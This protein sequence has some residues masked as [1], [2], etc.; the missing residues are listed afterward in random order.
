MNLTS[1]TAAAYFK[2]LLTKDS[3]LAHSILK[4]DVLETAKAMSKGYLDDNAQSKDIKDYILSSEAEKTAVYCAA[5]K[6]LM[7]SITKIGIAAICGTHLQECRLN[8]ML[9]NKHLPPFGLQ[10]NP[11]ADVQTTAFGLAQWMKARREGLY[12][13]A[14]ISSGSAIT[15][16]NPITQIKWL[17]AELSKNV[18]QG[19]NSPI[20]IEGINLK[21]AL[22]DPSVNITVAVR[23]FVR[24]FEGIKE[25]DAAN[26]HI[27]KRV[28]FA[29][30]VFN[31]LGNK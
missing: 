18:A 9:F 27:A 31:Q 29:T 23:L 24:V 14:R 2:T 16:L 10:I 11:S 6:F 12:Q 13:I 4:A 1:V 22:T 3:T 26:S 28:K 25:T 20:K 5:L 17:V 15:I 7:P 21:T 8:S 19:I 30:Q